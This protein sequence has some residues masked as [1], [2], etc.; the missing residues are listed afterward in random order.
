[1]TPTGNR[2]M[3]SS[4]NN[5]DCLMIYGA[6]AHKFA[7]V[8]PTTSVFFQEVWKSTGFTPPSSSLR[9]DPS[10]SSMVSGRDLLA[11]SGSSR[12]RTAP[13]R[14][15]RPH[16]TMG[17]CGLML[18][19]RYSMGARTPPVRAHM[20]PI[21]IPFCLSDS[22]VGGQRESEPTYPYWFCRVTCL[23][24][25]LGWSEQYLTYRPINLYQQKNR[26]VLT[27]NSI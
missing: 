20:E 22:G 16:R 5:T 2:L 25:I 7:L 27:C 26:P 19:R 10:T 3:E 17:A 9:L 15:Q 8:F 6:V 11:V 21:P 1:M 4:W 18:L 24:A 12:V 14:G 13:S 23:Q